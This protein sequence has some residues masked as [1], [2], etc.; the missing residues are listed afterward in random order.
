MIHRVMMMMV[1]MMVMVVVVVVVVV[2]VDDHHGLVAVAVLHAL[3][4]HAFFYHAGLCIF[5]AGDRRHC[6]R[7]GDQSR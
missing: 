2:V 7:D 1:M 3:F 4:V 5:S 6:E